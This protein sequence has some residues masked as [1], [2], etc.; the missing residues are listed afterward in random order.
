MVFGNGPVEEIA[1]FGDGGE[2]EGMLVECGQAHV[3]QGV[4]AFDHEG[5]E[6]E[7]ELERRA[8]V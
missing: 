2:K 8:V 3:G 6:D 1:V 5:V 4:P 7:T